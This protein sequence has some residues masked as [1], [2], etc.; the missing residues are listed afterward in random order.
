MVVT[1]KDGISPEARSRIS[2]LHVGKFYPPHPGGME[3]H[4]ETLCRALGKTMDVRAL[5]A[6]DARR[7]EDSIIDGVSVSRLAIGFHIAGAPVCVGMARKLRRSNA[8]IVHVHVPNPAGVLAVLASGY[9]GKLIVT[10][11]SDVVRQRRLA[12][13]FAPIQRRFLGKCSAIIA[14]SPNYVESSPDLACFRDKCHVV[15]FGIDADQ[16]R[17]VDREA[18]KAIRDRYPGPLLLS[19]GRLVY[20]KGFEYLV[21]AMREVKAT[22]L[23]VGEGPLRHSLEQET[24]AAGVADRVIF[25]GAVSGITPYYHA[26]DAFVL[27]SVSRSEA[28]GIVQLE[29][30]ACGKPV[31]NTQLQSGVPFVSVDGAT[32]STVEPRDSCEMARALNQL[33]D[34]RELRQQYGNAALQRVNAEFTVGAMTKRTLDLY[35]QVINGLPCR[36]VDQQVGKSAELSSAAI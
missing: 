16:F 4:L 5:V 13:I 18:V 29:A 33:L 15:P 30:M 8:D 11:H 23:I 25:L 6:N 36:A 32:G 14:S 3:T 24:R 35:D 34:D 20:Y 7:D 28:F 12:R 27:P 22:L 31:V 21:R 19:V 17:R 9:K 1:E 10:W 2:V 26:C